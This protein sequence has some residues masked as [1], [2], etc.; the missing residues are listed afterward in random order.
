[1]PKTKKPKYGWVKVRSRNAW[2]TSDWEYHEVE[3]PITEA[4]RDDFKEKYDDGLRG[5]DLRNVKAPPVRILKARVER[6]ANMI[7]HWRTQLD[8]IAPIY[9]K[10]LKARGLEDQCTECKSWDDERHGHD[11]DR[12]RFWCSKSKMKKREAKRKAKQN[13]RK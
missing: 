2:G 13:G 3:L 4:Q 7:T 9:E 6:A 5:Y 8:R 1:M 10:E 11:N 12:H